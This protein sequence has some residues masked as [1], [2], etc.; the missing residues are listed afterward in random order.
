MFNKGGMEIGFSA[1]KLALP[2]N[3]YNYG[4]AAI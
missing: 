1:T 2:V 3:Y 4:R